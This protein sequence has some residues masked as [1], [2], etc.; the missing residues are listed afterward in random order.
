MCILFSYIARRCVNPS[1]FKLVILSNRD[2]YFHRPSKTASFVD[3]NCLYGQ[4][5]TP[6]KEGGTWLGMSKFGKVSALLNLDR[7]DYADDDMNK[8]GRG[9]MIPNYLN[10]NFPSIKYV[11][12][13]ENDKYNPFNLLFYEKN[14]YC[15][16]FL[17]SQS[18]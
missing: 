9:F 7:L 2:E 5:L 3:N 11:E 16:Y 18:K 1:E 4:D 17:L 12:S 10:Q 8:A 14:E 6:G 15:F 13:I